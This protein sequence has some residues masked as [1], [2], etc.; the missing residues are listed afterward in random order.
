MRTPFSPP[1]RQ[2]HPLLNAKPHRENFSLS[3]R[4]EGE[5]HSVCLTRHK[6]RQFFYY[7]SAEMQLQPR[8]VTEDTLDQSCA[9]RARTCR[10]RVPAAQG[11]SCIISVINFGV[12]AISRA[13]KCTSNCASLA[14]ESSLTRLSTE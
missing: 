3:C 9:W 6:R 8:V 10:R 7:W 4:A 1:F 11:T 5:L 2:Q 14:C 13:S 12:M